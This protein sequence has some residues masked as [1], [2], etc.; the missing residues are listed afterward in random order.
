MTQ[1]CSV[2]DGSVQPDRSHCTAPSSTHDTDVRCESCR[3]RGCSVSTDCCI[4]RRRLSEVSEDDMEE[5]AV[6]AEDVLIDQISADVVSV[7][8]LIDAKCSLDARLFTLQ[9]VEDEDV[10]V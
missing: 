1:M 2:D 4:L 3:Y 8:L 10:F 6:G 7:E 9:F 5:V